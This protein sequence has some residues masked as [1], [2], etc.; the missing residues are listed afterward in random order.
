MVSLYGFSCGE[1]VDCLD[2][3]TETEAGLLGYSDVQRGSV[4]AG[5]AAVKAWSFAEARSSGGD[6]DEK[7][8]RHLD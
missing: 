8:D 4:D 6:G 1:L 3:L 5:G 7:P 2:K